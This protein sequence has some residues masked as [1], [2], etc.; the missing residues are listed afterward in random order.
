MDEADIQQTGCFLGSV[1][2]L[3]GKHPGLREVFQ[4]LGRVFIP[5]QRRKAVGQ[6]EPGTAFRRF[7]I[8]YLG[9]LNDL[10]EE[11]LSARHLLPL[12]VENA[13][14]KDTLVLP[15]AQAGRVAQ[16]LSLPKKV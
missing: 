15:V 8:C 1:I 2:N 5:A 10:P 6:A 14:L 7:V 12:N 9:G 4:P 16:A 13:L 11:G 3:A